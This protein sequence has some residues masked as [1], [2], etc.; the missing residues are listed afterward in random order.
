MISQTTVRYSLWIT[1][2]FNL[3]AAYVF[4]MSASMPAQLAGL[5]QPVHPLYSLL[6]ALFI[7]LFG[8]M[9]V[10]LARQPTLNQPLLFFGAAGKASVFV[11]AACLWLSGEVTAQIVYVAAA[12][13]ALA[14]LWFSWLYSQR[15][16]V[17]FSR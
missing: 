6:C 2:P 5:P 7:A 12:D 16:N 14:L 11:L 4:A 15:G 17:A 1:F 3:I 10:W 8:F 9:Y 13:L